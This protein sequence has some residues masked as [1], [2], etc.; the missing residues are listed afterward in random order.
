[1]IDDI[2]EAEL[3]GIEQRGASLRSR[4]DGLDRAARDR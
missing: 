3:T 1:M 4:A 2:E